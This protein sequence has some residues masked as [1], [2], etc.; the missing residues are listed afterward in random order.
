M[1]TMLVGRSFVSHQTIFLSCPFAWE[2]CQNC[3]LETPSLITPVV[4]AHRNWIGMRQGCGS[5]FSS[6][7]TSARYW[8]STRN[9][10]PHRRLSLALGL[11]CNVII[12]DTNHFNREDDVMRM[13]RDKEIGY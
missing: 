10:R 12:Q 1:A 7:D 13:L 6:W 11:P 2:G 9:D 5:H 8:I 3:P 4:I